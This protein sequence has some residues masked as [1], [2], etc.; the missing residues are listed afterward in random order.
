MGLAGHVP[1]G[2][3]KPLHRTDP[4]R[5]VAVTR[6]WVIRATQTLLTGHCPFDTSFSVENLPH[7]NDE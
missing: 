7:L 5:N 3:K 1:K 4:A 2:L 6:A